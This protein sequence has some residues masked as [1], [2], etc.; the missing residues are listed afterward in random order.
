MANIDK[1]SKKRNTNKIILII[2]LILLLL[3]NGFLL[4]RLVQKAD[5]EE[6]L[7]A[8]IELKEQLEKEVSDFKLEV[9]EY[10]GEIYEKDSTLNAY[11]SAM[12]TKVAQIEDLIKKEQIT[13]YQYN[14]ALQEIK[15]LE[16]YTQKYQTQIKELQKEN[17]I[18]TKENTTL[19]EDV[20]VYKK[21]V[22]NLTDKNVSLNNKVDLAAILKTDNI[23]VTGLQKKGGGKVKETDRGKRMEAMQI[24]FT[25]RENVL[26]KTGVKEFIVRII[27]PRGETLSME[28]RGGGKFNFMGDETLYTVKSEFEF[29]ND[30]DYLYTLVWDRGSP[31]EKGT[32]EIQVFNESII[33]G[34]TNFEV[35]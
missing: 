28:E 22:D 23:T 1:H 9:A 17:K 32:Y 20:K 2:L 14:K 18:L 34:K 33:I 24:S 19:K 16:Y 25:V 10:Q 26:A 7:L 31:F 35:K 29:K 30:P 3:F 15:K 8:T 6:D 4:L 11:K 5:V 13:R 21:E 12:E 27:N